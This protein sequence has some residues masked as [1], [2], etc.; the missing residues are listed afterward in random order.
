M[1]T[2][3]TMTDRVSG[4]RFTLAAWITAPRRREADQTLIHAPGLAPDIPPESA[5]TSGL[6]G[7]RSV[8][9]ERQDYRLYIQRGLGLLRFSNYT[10]GDH[11]CGVVD[12]GRLHHVAVVCDGEDLRFYLDGMH[13]YTF[14]VPGYVHPGG[15]A[16]RLGAMADGSAPFHGTIEN[17]LALCRALSHAE[18]RA[19]AQARKPLPAPAPRSRVPAA[20]LYED[21]LFNSARD[22]AVI[23]NRKEQNWWFVYVQQRN[24]AGGPG[25]TIAYGDTLGAASSD[26]G[27]LTWKYRGFLQGLEPRPGANTFWAPDIVWDGGCYH[28]IVTRVHGIHA[29]WIGDRRLLHYTSDNLMDW[30]LVGPVADLEAPLNLDACAHRLPDGQWGLWYRDDVADNT[31]FATGPDL[32]SLRKVRGFDIDRGRR[33]LEGADVFQWKGFYWLIGDDRPGYRGVR[34]YRSTDA[35]IWD[36]QPLILTGDVPG[37]RPGDQGT[38]HHPEV[39]VHGDEAYVF[40]WT[41]N[42]AGDVGSYCTVCLLQV[43]KLGFADGRLTCDRNAEFELNLPMKNTKENTP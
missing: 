35:R 11:G 17:P 6:S 18:I 31:A 8:L 39:I 40:Y 23:W 15:G 22:G 3:T 38:A 33:S 42:S 2:C 7:T 13:L 19:L 37:K 24:G 28:L 12:T 27:G 4:E 10:I 21:P 29:D 30:T 34:V 43:A 16:P 32:H 14:D 26:D 25:V 36:E 1:T 9:Q 5:Q 20:P 41:A